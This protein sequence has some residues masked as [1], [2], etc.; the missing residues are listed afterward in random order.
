MGV[1]TGSDATYEEAMA[2]FSS[3]GSE[4]VVAPVEE[5]GGGGVVVLAT[6][7][8]NAMSPLQTRA[9]GL[10]G[11]ICDHHTVGR[12]LAPT[13]TSRLSDSS[14]LL[15]PHAWASCWLPASLRC[16]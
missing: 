3:S 15:R 14:V 16:V 1:A 9:P 5:E 10:V 11:A 7:L 4:S 2:A 6:H 12:E 8:F 13:I